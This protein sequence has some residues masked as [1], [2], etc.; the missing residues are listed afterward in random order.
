M[1]DHHRR[2]MLDPVL[3]I[4]N[5]TR[6]HFYSIETLGVKNPSNRVKGKIQLLLVFRE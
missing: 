3:A 6:E 4:K 5:F 1:W 2:K